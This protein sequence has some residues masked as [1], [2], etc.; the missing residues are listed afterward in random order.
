VSAE[1]HSFPE[2]HLQ[3]VIDDPQHFSY[4]KLTLQQD[5]LS[6]H[7]VIYGCHKFLWTI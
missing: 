4:P 7:K 1:G 5:R 3:V 6:S 2:G